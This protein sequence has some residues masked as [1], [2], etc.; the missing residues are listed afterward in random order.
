MSWNRVATIGALAGAAL[1]VGTIAP[2]AIAGVPADVCGKPTAAISR[3][4]AGDGRYKVKALGTETCKPV[5]G[6]R[7]SGT[8]TVESYHNY[9]FFADPRVAYTSS[10]KSH[11][12]DSKT[13]KWSTGPSTCDNFTTAEYYAK[14]KFV[15]YK[16]L[17][18][19]ESGNLKIASC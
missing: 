5:A 14:S 1:V 19:A 10:T 17:R 4:S 3:V 8:L 16:F 2:A 18:T 11:G 9:D 6:G 12:N 15:I 13:T 7:W